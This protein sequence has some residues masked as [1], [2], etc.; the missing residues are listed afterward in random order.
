MFLD[1]DG[2]VIE[3]RHYL[4]DPDGV[5]LLPGAA[6]A[7]ASLNAAGWPVVVVTNQSGVGRGFITEA[8]YRSTEKRLGDLLADAGAVLT[9][10]YHCPH[11]PLA[12]PACSC[13]KP[14]PGLFELAAREHGLDLSRS[15]FVGDRLRDVEPGLALGGVG[16]LLHA[17]HL[18]RPRVV[19]ARVRLVDSLRAAVDHILAS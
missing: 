14:L 15:H 9:A 17:D 5:R 8:Q 10:T 12:L 3:D 1:R 16:Y 6:S 4:A 11:D 13:R 18:P 2:T 7:I 19:H